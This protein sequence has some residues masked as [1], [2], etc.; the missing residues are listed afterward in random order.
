MKMQC[1]NAVMDE[2]RPGQHHFSTFACERVHTEEVRREWIVLS[3]TVWM[4]KG[5]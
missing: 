5:V 3:M 4:V 1:R 2:A